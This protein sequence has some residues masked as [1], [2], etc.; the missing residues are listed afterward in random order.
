M[1][2]WG[3]SGLNQ[4]PYRKRR[5]IS[6]G[7]LRRWRQIYREEQEQIIPKSITQ[8]SVLAAK[9]PAKFVDELPLYR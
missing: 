5:G 7:S 1:A 4:Q 8:Y 6:L 9:I 2:Y 3:R